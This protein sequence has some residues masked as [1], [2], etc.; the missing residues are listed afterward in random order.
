MGE[1]NYSELKWEQGDKTQLRA[2]LLQTLSD[3]GVLPE[4]GPKT[5]CQAC[6]QHGP[7]ADGAHLNLITKERPRYA[8]TREWNTKKTNCIENT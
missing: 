7:E 1:T 8:E 6:G 5:R 3:L 2:K 4:A